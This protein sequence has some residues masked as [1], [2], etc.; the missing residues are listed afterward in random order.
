MQK[1][2]LLLVVAISIVGCLSKPVPWQP[3]DVN[4][5]SL[6][7]AAKADGK[8]EVRGVPPDVA[9]EVP[10]IVVEIPELV[11]KDLGEIPD[12][13]DVPG[14]DVSKDAPAVELV[15]VVDAVDIVDVDAI[16]TCDP[17][18]KD[19][20]FCI[21]GQCHPDYCTFGLGEQGCCLEGIWVKC[22]GEAGLEFTDCTKNQPPYDTCGW[23]D[24]QYECGGDGAAPDDN[25]PMD[26]CEPDCEGKQ[27]GWDECW[28]TCGECTGMQEAC[29]EGVCLCQPACDGKDCGPDGCGGECG[30]CTVCGKECQEGQ[31]VFVNCDG[32]ECGDDGCDG[33]CGLCKEEDNE[34][35]SAGQCVCTDAECGELCCAPGEV[36]YEA[37]CCTPDCTGKVCGSDGCGGQCIP[38]CDDGKG[39]TADD[40]TDGACS[41]PVTEGCLIDGECVAGEGEDPDEFCMYCDPAQT[42]DD[43]SPKTD[44]VTCGINADCQGGACACMYEECLDACCDNG[45][46][47]FGDQCCLPDCGGKEC[48]K[49]GCGGVC[50]ELV[51]ECPGPQD[52]C[53]EGACICQ[54]ACDGKQCGPDGCDGSCGDCGEGNECQE[55]ICWG[56]CGDGVCGDGETCTSCPGDCGGCVDLDC[57][58]DL[59]KSIDTSSGS[60]CVAKTVEI[61]SGVFWMGC[62]WWEGS[63]VYDTYCGSNEHPI[64]EVYL[65]AYEIDVTEVTVDQYKACVA[66]EGACPFVSGA[67]CY[68]VTPTYLVPGQVEH[69]VNCVTWAQA[70][71]YCAW[72]G[73]QLCTEAQWEKAARGGCEFYEEGKCKA[74]AM[75]FPWG[76]DTPECAEGEGDAVYDSCFDSPQP[77]A[78]FPGADSLYGVHDMAGNVGEWA[79]DWYNYQYYESSPYYNPEA[80]WNKWEAGLFRGG[81]YNDSYEA[82]RV[83]WRGVH[84]RDGQLPNVGFRCCAGIDD[85]IPDCDGKN[86]ATDGCGGTC[87]DQEGECWAPLEECEAGVCTC[88]PDCD[89]K[90]CGDDGCGG[91]CGECVDPEFCYDSFC[92]APIVLPDTGQV[93]CYGDES[94]ISC[95]GP[96]ELFHGQDAN[97]IGV[98]LSYQDNGDG[99]VTDLNTGLVWAKCPGGQTGEDC[100]GEA[101]KLTWQAGV[102]YC[103]ENTQGLPGDG[104]R[105]ASRLELFTLLDYGEVECIDEQHFG[106]TGDYFWSATEDP[107]ASA[108]YSVSYTTCS[109]GDALAKVAKEYNV[110]CV[111]GSQLTLGKNQDVGDGTVKDLAAG[112]VWQKADG[113]EGRTWGAAL[114]YCEL[115]NL[116]GHADWRLPSSRELLTLM[117][118]ALPNE[119]LNEEF[120]PESVPPEECAHYWSATS[121][122]FK[123]SAAI[124]AKC[125]GGLGS[126]AHLKTM[127][128]LTRCVRQDCLPDCKGREC[129]DDGCGSTCGN[130]AEG[131]CDGEYGVCVKPGWVVIPAGTFTMGSPEWENCRQDQEGP[132][133]DVTVTRPLVVSDHEVTQSEWT[134]ITGA[135]NPSFFGPEGPNGQCATGD[136]PVE[137]VN[138][139]EA[140]TYVNL[141]SESEGLEACYTLTGCNGTLGGGCSGQG[142]CSGDYTCGALFAGLDC[143]GYRLPTEAEWEY[144]ARAGTTDAFAY[145]VQGG[146]PKNPECGCSAE[147][148]LEQYG[149]YCHNSDDRTHPVTLKAANAW[150]LHDTSGNVAEWCNDWHQ[151][152]YY[153]ATPNV[154]PMGGTEG[155]RIV[156]GGRWGNV[157]MLCRSAFRESGAPCPS[158]ER[159]RLGE[160]RGLSS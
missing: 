147:A 2:V 156:R 108:A 122:R 119:S 82:L 90:E 6:T 89:G 107:D 97:Y 143:T 81:G 12:L 74:Q 120:F 69:A 125:N 142:S 46:I 7:D 131:E 31:C 118:H 41:Y 19:G 114:Q 152:D 53:I 27:C 75:M 78:G 124:V 77:P 145:P 59:E 155:N 113:G 138:W 84:S 70:E 105:L 93:R 72:A 17:A 76:N 85:C 116:G 121:F 5:D 23:K 8:G 15:E 26:C 134:Q 149:W 62:N 1:L 37:A 115:L 110:R 52:E 87:G 88:Q 35:C 56:S 111:N 67:D 117:D 20:E 39:C 36:C 51:G 48:G 136:C 71:A 4:V 25:P 99:T 148:N 98:P 45:Q 34:F 58:P 159:A 153:S 63:E 57:D 101:A 24:D 144:L 112:L 16:E 43:W 9:P 55:G 109:S 66:D 157:A 10:D 80:G 42:V 14:I 123:P 139:Y 158:G 22:D 94:E 130:C 86:C 30:T 150:G 32:V 96:G 129:G 128:F 127:E 141:L 29:V 91:S 137:L 13:P 83:S 18:C 100:A 106:G 28:G 40:C 11:T 3:G 50:G 151:L 104:W 47:C 54:P 61:P 79:K 140:V 154:D 133:H 135:P 103:A 21:V 38:G 33:S 64:H 132:L 160:I 73:K 92:F 65:D 44:G 60:A 95:P 126:H 146:G 102:E 68:G 49:D